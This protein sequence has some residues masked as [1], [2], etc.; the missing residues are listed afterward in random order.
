MEHDVVSIYSTKLTMFSV[1]LA[2]LYLII[3]HNLKFFFNSTF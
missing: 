3:S 1:N 2:M